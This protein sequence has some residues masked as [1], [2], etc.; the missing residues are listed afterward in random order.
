MIRARAEAVKNIRH[1][2]ASWRD[3]AVLIGGHDGSG[4]QQS[5]SGGRNFL[6]LFMSAD[7]FAVAPALI[8]MLSSVLVR[9]AVMR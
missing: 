4:L 1:A 8:V 9:M 6:P 7:N 2:T 3:A 5:R